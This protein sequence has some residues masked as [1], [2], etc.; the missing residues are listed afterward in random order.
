MQMSESII[1]VTGLPRSGTSMMMKML[2]SGGMEVVIDNIRKAD[3]DNPEG[4]YEFEKVKKLKEDASWLDGVEGKVVKMASMLLYDLPSDKNYRLIFMKRNLEEILLS[5]RKMLERN[6][7]EDNI[8][9]E[10]M[11]RLFSKHLEEIEGWLSGQQNLEV[12]YV[13]YNDML[14]KPQENVRNLNGFLDNILDTDRMIKV[15]DASLYRN[16]KTGGIT[17]Q[18]KEPENVPESVKD[19]EKIKARL[20]ELGYM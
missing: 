7:A 11:R 16:K 19:D 4:Y 18:E 5:Q 1:I 10:E 6:G 2:Q 20:S 17:A 13:D 8:D 12:L 9:D 15:V 3:E 14:K